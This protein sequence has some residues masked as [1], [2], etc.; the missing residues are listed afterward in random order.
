MMTIYQ[1]LIR[2]MK[3]CQ[4]NIPHNNASRL[5]ILSRVKS[6]LLS[7]IVKYLENEITLPVVDEFGFPLPLIQLRSIKSLS[8][9]S[10]SS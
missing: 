6:S 8:L 5:S 9:D 3:D 4:L 7:R 1:N 2:T 10:A